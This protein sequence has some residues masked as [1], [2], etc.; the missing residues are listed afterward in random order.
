MYTMSNIFPQSISNE[1]ANRYNKC[2]TFNEV[3]E[4]V[5]DA[6]EIVEI[7]CAVLNDAQWILSHTT[8]AENVF[9]KIESLDLA[10]TTTQQAISNEEMKKIAQTFFKIFY[11]RS[12]SGCSEKLVNFTE[13]AAYFLAITDIPLENRCEFMQKLDSLLIKAIDRKITRSILD[14]LVQMEP[15]ESIIFLDLISFLYRDFQGAITANEELCI[16][17]ANA[18]FRQ[19]GKERQKELA[20]LASKFFP[21]ISDHK[22]YSI[23]LAFK[24]IPVEKISNAANKAYE[25][26]VDLE[27]QIDGDAVGQLL[28]AIA[29]LEN[30]GELES[31]LPICQAF[32]KQTADKNLGLI[33]IA[34]NKIAKAQKIA[35]DVLCSSLLVSSILEITIAAKSKEKPIFTYTVAELLTRSAELTGGQMSLLVSEASA[36]LDILP[37][38]AA[39]I[40]YIEL[41]EAV[42]D[43]T[44]ELKASEIKTFFS[45]IRQICL[46]NPSISAHRIISSLKAI[47]QD[48]SRHEIITLTKTLCDKIKDIPPDE[49]LKEMVGISPL[50]RKHFVAACEAVFMIAVEKQLEGKFWRSIIL[51]R[52]FSLAKNMAPELLQKSLPLILPL[53]KGK[54]LNEINRIL[55][56][57]IS[58]DSSMIIDILKYAQPFSEDKGI[59]DLMWLIEIVIRNQKTEF[60]SCI[61]PL[62]EKMVDKRGAS[63]ILET[64]V[65]NCREVKIAQELVAE[66]LPFA[67]LNADV[68]AAYLACIP[69]MNRSERAGFINETF[70]IFND[71]NGY[72]IC[73]YAEQLLKVVAAAP[74]PQ[75][76]SAVE[77]AIKI[78]KDG[79]CQ[80]LPDRGFIIK[81]LL[82]LPD[83]KENRSL[84]SLGHI[85]NYTE[86]LLTFISRLPADKL[87]AFLTSIP[88]KLDN[89]LR[90]SYCYPLLYAGAHGDLE[91]FR[92]HSEL[93]IDDDNIFDMV[94][95]TLNSGEERTA[96]RAKLKAFPPT[97]HSVIPWLQ[98]FS[99][100]PEHHRGPLIRS[101][102]EYLHGYRFALIAPN[103]FDKAV[104]MCQGVEDSSQMLRALWSDGDIVEASKAYLLQQ[105]NSEAGTPEE[106]RL[107]TKI[108][109]ECRSD[110]FL[111][112]ED[113]LIQKAIEVAVLCDPSMLNN[114]TNPYALYSMLK[115]VLKGEELAVAPWRRPLMAEDL[116]AGITPDTLADLCIAMQ[117]RLAAVQSDELEGVSALFDALLGDTAIRLLL[118]PPTVGSGS[119]ALPQYQL[120]KIVEL[121]NSA[122]K[123]SITSE[124]MTE[125]ERLL[126]ALATALKG[127]TA[128]TLEKAIDGFYSKH[129][130]ID[131][132]VITLED[133]RY[134]W[135]LNALRS[136][137][138]AL[139]RTYTV[140]DLPKGIDATTPK[141]LI[142][143]MKSRLSEDTAAAQELERSLAT[144]QA[145]NLNDLLSELQQGSSVRELLT[146]TTKDKTAPISVSKLILHRNLAYI[147]E[148]P[149]T[150]ANGTL[151]T[152]RDDL[153]L[154]LA[155]RV[156]NCPTGQND[157]SLQFYNSCVPLSIKVDAVRLLAD[158]EAALQATLLTLIDQCYEEMLSNATLIQ[159][160]ISLDG[161]LQQASHQTLY[162][163]NRFHMLLG[164]MT[165]RLTFDLNSGVLYLRLLELIPH[166]VIAAIC[167]RA[168]PRLSAMIAAKS[169]EF[170]YTPM[171]EL[172]AQGQGKAAED[173]NVDEVLNTDYD[174]TNDTFTYTLKPEG[175]YSLLKGAGFLAE[176]K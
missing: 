1:I 139:R 152:M 62:W 29:D 46:S 21:I 161:E 25:I 149:L 117:Q 129:I 165:H 124:G 126:C 34:L 58:R 51:G 111:D 142:A 138:A 38:E 113:P 32:I 93:A 76:R 157:G 171:L 135:K 130:A 168:L 3:L 131:D 145:I 147:A 41:C 132:T 65:N 170:P 61:L 9:R 8:D 78:F 55:Q 158:K 36:F 107:L 92:E 13:T 30:D 27:G 52:L 148:A 72:I 101:M 174:E 43:L 136:T 96:A 35:P 97:Q 80:S 133:K 125:S 31:Y 120:C 83:L 112:G 155:A 119:I 14:A 166:Q 10:D 162:L 11:S 115:G 99:C 91:T 56:A 69:T 45:D 154:G 12:G 95:A 85:Y 15:Q 26:V 100:I 73:Y 47:A 106:K 64:V 48:P 18:G 68:I 75:R 67:Q 116:P 37:Q 110:L 44:K 70:P 118:T 104:S 7:C 127:G 134:L 143:E 90:L 173:L 175:V 87:T 108:I 86:E 17:N 153:L 122:S 22:I 102:S 160:L 39:H 137:I 82:L 167:G 109:I 164:M 159:S 89:A 140:G 50:S 49:V 20:E 123:H 144:D 71:F 128:G 121:I 81:A 114:P 150:K 176:L 19:I 141:K 60:I 57:I 4:R 156:R 103:V 88:L 169:P 24:F 163:K 151:L 6:H 28:L 74:Y 53:C 40:T 23:L 77:R 84:L 16:L 66:L 146:T 79:N 54:A 59:H 105:L 94:V 98:L 5:G 33:I 2:T 63:N 42:K 172:I